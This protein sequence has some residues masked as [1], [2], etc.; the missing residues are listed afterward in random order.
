[1]QEKIGFLMKKALFVVF[2]LTAVLLNSAIAED[3]VKY[4]DDIR[5]VGK[6]EQPSVSLEPQ[7][8]LI[9]IETYKSPTISQNVGDILKD[10]VIMDYRAE[11]DLVPGYDTLYMRG[12]SSK[13]FVTALDGFQIRN[14]G[15]RPTTGTVDYSLLPPFLIDSIEILPGPHSALYPGES[16]GGVINFKIHEPKPYETLKPD[17]SVSTSY[18]AYDTQQHNLSLRGGSGNLTY[19]LGYQKYFTN[20]YLRNNEADIDNFFGRFGYLLP[21]NGYI[22]LTTSYAHIDREVPVKN[23]RDDPGS[24]YDGDYPEVSSGAGSSYSRFYAWQHPEVQKTASHYQLNFKLPTS[25][26]NCKANAYYRLENHDRPTLVWVKPKDHSNATMDGSW[27]VDFRQQGG[28]ISNEF[29]LAPGHTTNIGG[30]IEQLYDKEDYYNAEKS[31]RLMED[32]YHKRNENIFGFVQHKWAILPELLLTAGLRYEDNTVWAS[33]YCPWQDT[34]HVPGYGTWAKETYS[35]WMPKSFF[36]YKLDGLAD[37]LRDTSISL[38]ISRIWRSPGEIVECQYAGVPQI[39]WL[40]PEHGVG[41]D[42]IFD[43]RLA[44]NIHMQLNYSY[45]RIKDY[46]ARNNLFTNGN[47]YMINLDEVIRQGIELQFAGSLTDSL[48]FRL[49]YAWQD[50]ENKGD[51]LA[52]KTELDDRAKNRINAGLSWRLFEG[53]TLMFDYEYQDDQTIVITDEVEGDY[54]FHEIAL[55]SYHVVDLAVEQ[56]LFDKWRNLKNCVLKIYVKNLFDKEYQ[57][58]NGYPALDCTVGAGISFSL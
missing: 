33:N 21:N 51:E 57:N 41:Y 8:T 18:G 44:G 45:S 3:S 14:T 10:F 35:E 49:G 46:I 9:K 20:G 16:L 13:R 36:T 25:W 56:T 15:G 55:D 23:D 47:Q 53:T 24:D 39:V 58:T 32:R 54:E 38:G 40:D 6:K 42:V 19:D 11:S 50:F 48:D 17:V 31:K 5:V 28:Q 22:A 43:R 7:K 30:G 2:L 52:G 26:G 4:I 1:M 34:F 29:N 37:E 27:D 12:F